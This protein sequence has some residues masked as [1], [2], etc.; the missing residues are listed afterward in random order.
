MFNFLS[1][2]ELMNINH[3]EYSGASSEAVHLLFKGEMY[4]ISLPLKEPAEYNNQLT[5]IS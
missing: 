3:N 2:L 4:K 5:T 1:N